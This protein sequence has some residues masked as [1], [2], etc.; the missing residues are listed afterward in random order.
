MGVIPG[1]GIRAEER[2][3]QFALN[4]RVKDSSHNTVI[5]PFLCLVSIKCLLRN[6]VHVRDEVKKD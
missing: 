5:S 6:S 3:N 2:L 4:S 1:K